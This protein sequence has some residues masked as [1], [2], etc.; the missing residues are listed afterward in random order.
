MN[1]DIKERMIDHQVKGGIQVELFLKMVL[2][3]TDRISILESGKK[4][5]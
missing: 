3:L 2:D 4:R 1:E 5:L